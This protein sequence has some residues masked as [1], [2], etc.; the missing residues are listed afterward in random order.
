MVELLREVRRCGFDVA[1][2]GGG[3]KLVRVNVRAAVPGP[4]MDELRVRRDEVIRFLSGGEEGE[5][6]PL[7]FAWT[8]SPPDAPRM[9]NPA[10]RPARTAAVD[11]GGRPTEA[12]NPP[13]H[14]SLDPT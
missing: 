9:C 12:T 14:Y 13:C 11:P 10:T 1:L 5:T 4:V 6:C 8:R 2:D 3:P 7:C